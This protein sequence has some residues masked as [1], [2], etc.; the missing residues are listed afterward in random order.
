MNILDI[1]PLMPYPPVFGGARGVLGQITSLC[2]RGHHIHLFCLTEDENPFALNELRRTCAVDVV[3]FRRRPGLRSALASL[4]QQAPYQLSRFHVPAFL[5]RMREAMRRTAFDI[6]QA[7]GIHTA[8][9]AHALASE[10]SIPTVM[11]IHNLQY[12]QMSRLGEVDGNPARKLWLAYETPKV[13]TYERDAYAKFTVNLAISGVEREHLCNLSPDAP[14]EVIPAGIDPEEFRP[15]GDVETPNAVLWTGSFGHAP[16]VDS[17]RWFCQ[18]I[19]PRILRSNSGVRVRIVGSGTPTCAPGRR[20]PAAQVIGCVPDI[21]EELERAQVCVVPLR[22]GS[23]VRVK[24]L[25]MLAMGKAIVSTR[26][27]AEGL[28]VRDGEHLLIADTPEDFGDAVARLLRDHCLR[29][30][31]GGAAREY[32]GKNHAWEIIAPRFE[33]AYRSVLDKRGHRSPPDG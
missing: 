4:R 15:R 16:N 18:E 5:D 17:C 8:S 3:R 32:I 11:R 14:C 12:L 2:A 22:A 31:L 13:R 33:S 30:H 9:Y 29:A 19:V 7:E 6:I 23:G 27:G 28:D 25:E 26:M 20:D 21:R 24:L 1:S 10:F